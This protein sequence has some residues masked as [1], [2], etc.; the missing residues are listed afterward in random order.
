MVELICRR[1]SS[2]ILSKAIKYSVL[3]SGCTQRNVTATY[4]VVA[5]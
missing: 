5:L 3:L 4:S 2:R 1:L